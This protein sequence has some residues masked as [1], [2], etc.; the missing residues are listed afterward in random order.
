MFVQ[1]LLLALLH[2]SYQAPL[3]AHPLVT[4]Q[5]TPRLTT[6]AS[7]RFISWNE[8][9]PVTLTT[10]T[11][12]RKKAIKKD[13]LSGTA[14]LGYTLDPCKQHSDCIG[15]RLCITGNFASSCNGRKTCI[16]IGKSVQLCDKNC[17]ECDNYPK[18]TCGYL[19]EDVKAKKTPTGVCVSTYTVFEGL[20]VEIACDS[21]PDITPF[22]FYARS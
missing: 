14:P 2:L 15:D 8:I 19:P 20:I 6:S 1:L 10:I 21:F 3:V 12:A 16:C 22:P 13:T 5:N 4:E 11:S 9:S 7:S 18:E 17:T